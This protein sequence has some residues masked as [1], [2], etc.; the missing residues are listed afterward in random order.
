VDVRSIGIGKQRV[1]I[2][3]DEPW[4]K[5]RGKWT[6]TP[7]PAR[8]RPGSDEHDEV[9]IFFGR[10][11]R[12]RL[13]GTR[14]RSGTDDAVVYLRLKPEGWRPALYEI[15]QL[16]NLNVPGGLFG[17]LGHADPEVV[18]KVGVQC[19]IKRLTGW[20]AVA[21]GP[22]RPQVKLCGARAW[23]LYPEAL[24][25]MTES[26]W[27]R[28]PAPVPWKK[29]SGFWAIDERDAW[30][31]V[32]SAG[33]LYHYDGQRWSEHASVV[34]RPREMWASSSDDV[35]LVGDDGAAHFDGTRWSRVRGPAG[36]LSQIEG[37]SSQDLW[38]GGRSGLWHGTSAEAA[39]ERSPD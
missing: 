6:P 22:D 27:Q 29:P 35:W 30:V 7:I 23:A 24:A 4:I 21:S 10:D 32:A 18:C 33:Q 11:D 17:V 36:P 26:G 25:Q 31:A 1:A 38:L 16:G 15:G 28:L 2:L 5:D 8:Y 14:H 3:S 34:A 19:I 12:P 13:M 9:R 37:I 39:P 20:T